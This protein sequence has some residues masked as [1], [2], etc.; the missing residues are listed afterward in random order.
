M[1]R[2]HN[3]SLTNRAPPLLV[4]DSEPAPPDSGQDKFR[5]RERERETRERRY[6]RIVCLNNGGSMLQ[7]FYREKE[8]TQK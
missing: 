5:E 2:L 4:E 6:G 8:R 3:L 1:A 7:L